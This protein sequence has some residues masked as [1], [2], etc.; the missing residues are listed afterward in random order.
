[1]VEKMI[2]DGRLVFGGKWANVTDEI[3]VCFVGSLM[4]GQK[5]LSLT[6][7]FTTWKITMK[8]AVFVVRT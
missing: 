6:D 1:M 8:G 2:I 5:R 3:F 7:I 4:S